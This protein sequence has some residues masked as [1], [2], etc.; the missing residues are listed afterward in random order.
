M[1]EC[2]ETDEVE[3]VERGE[4]K[5]K[6]TKGEVYLIRKPTEQDSGTGATKLPRQEDQARIV[7]RILAVTT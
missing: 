7:T 1:K 2:F 3:T 6:T 5:G 4:P